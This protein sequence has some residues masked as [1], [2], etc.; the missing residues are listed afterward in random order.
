M[1]TRYCRC[2]IPCVVCL[3]YHILSLCIISSI[4]LH[5]PQGPCAPCRLRARR[6]RRAHTPTLVAVAVPP[7]SC[8][9]TPFTALSCSL[10]AA[11]PFH[12]LPTT[13]HI[14][15]II[16][17]DATHATYA[18][19][20]ACYHASHRAPLASASASSWLLFFFF[21]GLR[22]RTRWRLRW[23]LSRDFRDFSFI[24]GLHENFG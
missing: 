6:A 17:P 4:Q 2:V 24:L 5:P 19:C 10:T 11:P 13:T 21:F 8:V 15:G 7:T 18:S 23:D 22:N 12:Y 9:F 1:P 3:V 20:R 14:A 16:T